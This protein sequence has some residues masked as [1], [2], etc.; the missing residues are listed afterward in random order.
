MKFLFIVCLVFCLDSFSQ[1]VATLAV[2]EFEKNLANAQIQLLDVRRPEE[3]K[4]GHLR[5]AFQADWLNKQQF[6]ERIQHLDKTKPVY[7]YCLAGSRSAAAANWL[8][9]NGFSILVNLEG[10]INAWKKEGKSLESGVIVDQMKDEEYIRLVHS[11][12]LVLVD[13]GAEWC[14]PCKKMA[15]VIDS[16]EKEH[17]EIKL[18]KID[19]GVEDE[20]VKKYKIDGLPVFVL[21]KSGKEIWRQEGII[22]KKELEEVIKKFT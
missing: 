16:F 14:I 1:N 7:V 4:A 2:N 9:E 8:A 10:G 19:A 3:Y 6:E 5:G 11:A 13:F 15:P 17:P 21:Y 12:A 18:V 20:I 22:T